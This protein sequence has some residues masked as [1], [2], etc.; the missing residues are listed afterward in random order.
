MKPFKNCDLILYCIFFFLMNNFKSESF[1]F[2]FSTNPFC[3]TSV[4]T[5]FLFSFFI[6]NN[7]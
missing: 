5:W 6:I 1:T 7:F 4:F 2:I 3:H